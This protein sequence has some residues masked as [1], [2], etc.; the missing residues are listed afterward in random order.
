M[1]QRAASLD[2]TDRTL[3]IAQNALKQLTKH[4]PNFVVQQSTNQNNYVEQTTGVLMFIDINGF[5]SLSEEYGMRHQGGV[6]DLTSELN[7]YMTKVVKQIKKYGGDV[8][9]F[10][11]DAVLCWWEL[12]DFFDMDSNGGY[13]KRELQSIALM[14]IDCANEIHKTCDFYK[15]GDG[16][17]L[18]LKTALSYGPVSKMIFWT[19][20]S[21]YYF[22]LGKAV[23]TLKTCGNKSEQSK[24]YMTEE[25][26][27]LVAEKLI[28]LQRVEL[29]SEEE[30][31]KVVAVNLKLFNDDH[32][33]DKKKTRSGSYHP[34]WNKS[35]QWTKSPVE[36]SFSRIQ[37]SF[38]KVRL[39]VNDVFSM[40]SN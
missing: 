4:V 33:P 9:K 24:I 36:T 14:V 17:L 10:A 11:G 16:K 39:Q 22:L 12:S 6:D 5:T 27:G 13:D 40:R 38:A 23:D 3:A 1:K 26:W 21:R 29:Y 31:M 32:F 18:S 15:T 28:K 2:D 7:K 30:D 19:S 37:S 8:V 25:F 20:T 34:R 35:Y